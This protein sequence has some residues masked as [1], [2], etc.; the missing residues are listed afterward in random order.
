VQSVYLFCLSKTVAFP[1]KKGTFY[2]KNFIHYPFISSNIRLKSSDDL[3]GIVIF[4]FPF[5]ATFTSTLFPK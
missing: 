4:P 3:N 2:G 1:I 5:A